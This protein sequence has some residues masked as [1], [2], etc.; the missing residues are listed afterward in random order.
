MEEEGTAED[1]GSEPGTSGRDERLETSVATVT[2]L[3]GITI[4]IYVQNILIIYFSIRIPERSIVSYI[5]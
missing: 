1:D 5:L 4:N 2:E 3:S